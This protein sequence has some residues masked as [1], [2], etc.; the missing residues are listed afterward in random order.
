MAPEVLRS[1]RM[2]QA[3]DVY[4][5]GAIMWELAQDQSISVLCAFTPRLTFRSLSTCPYRHQQGLFAMCSFVQAK[6]TCL[7]CKGVILQLYFIYVMFA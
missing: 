3:S 5:F 2:H 1:R 4:S 7:L 6:R